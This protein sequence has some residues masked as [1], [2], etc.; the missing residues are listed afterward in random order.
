MYHD[1]ILLQHSSTVRS[2]NFVTLFRQI[3]AC[4]KVIIIGSRKREIWP[5]Q[6]IRSRM[7][8][9]YIL[10]QHSSTVKSGNVVTLFNQL[11]CQRDIVMESDLTQEEG[12]LANTSS[13]PIV[14][15]AELN[16]SAIRG[17]MRLG[18]SP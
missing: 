3:F 7:K 17:H 6:V 10:L 1:Y 16:F 14:S 8:S 9:D 5:A 2:G 18:F 13:Q 4:Q 11:F 12:K 15:T